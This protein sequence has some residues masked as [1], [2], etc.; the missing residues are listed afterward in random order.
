MPLHPFQRA[1]L[2]WSIAILSVAALIN[3]IWFDASVAQAVRD[4]GSDAWLKAK[5]AGGGRFWSDVMKFPG[6]YA[7]ALL[8]A[9]TAGVIAARPWRRWGALLIAAA[10]L[11]SGVN[12]VLKWV[13]GRMRPFSVEGVGWHDFHPFHNGIAGFFDQTNLS[14]PS[15]HATHSFALAAALWIVW[16][17]FGWLG[18]VAALLTC[19]ERVASNSHYLSEVCMGAALGLI[20]AMFA[21]KLVAPLAGQLRDIA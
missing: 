10:S 12:V 20:V 19:F 13:V 2:L 8:M 18:F 5:G 4:S 16:P 14:F 3:F 15:G 6:V 21:R 11:F 17:R 9:L 7:S 1:A